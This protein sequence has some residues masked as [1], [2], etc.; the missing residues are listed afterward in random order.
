MIRR[1]SLVAAIAAGTLGVSSP[2]EAT[3]FDC[4]IVVGAGYGK[5]TCHAGTGRQRARGQY[6]NG[7]QY[8]YVTGPC[9]GVHQTSWV[10]TPNGYPLTA[11]FPQSC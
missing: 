7:V 9:V 3:L 1:L 6:H 8:G 4:D 10:F 5:T 11:L 2:A